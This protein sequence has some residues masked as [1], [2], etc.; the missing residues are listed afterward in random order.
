[1]TIDIIYMTIAF[2]ISD[3]Y[4]S[5]FFTNISEAKLGGFSYVMK[6]LISSSLPSYIS[7]KVLNIKIIRVTAISRQ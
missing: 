1:M 4:N 5:D 2:F 3:M 6:Y 7:K